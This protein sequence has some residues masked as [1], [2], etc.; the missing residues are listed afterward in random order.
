MPNWVIHTNIVLVGFMGSGKSSIGR[1]VAGRLRFRFIDTDHVIVERAGMDISEIFRRHGEAHFRALESSVLESL[2][3]LDRHVIAT[4]G[5]IVLREDNR[6]RLRELG[7]VVG[8]KASESVIVE[9]VSRNTRRPLL[10]TGD[11]GETV[12]RCCERQPLGGS[13]V[14]D[15]Y[16]CLTHTEVAVLI[17]TGARLCVAGCDANGLLALAQTSVCRVPDCTLHGRPACRAISA[18]G[19]RVEC[20]RY[21]QLSRKT[22]RRTDPRQVLSEAQSVVGWR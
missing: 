10:Q 4:G 16:T 3:P 7:F 9:R 2:V 21:D 20:G 17:I 11:P 1:L 6:A 14:H 12:A 22:E 13:A 5:G 19:W 15:R 18:D 8:L